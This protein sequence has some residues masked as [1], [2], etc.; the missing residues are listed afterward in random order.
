MGQ[1]T[2]QSFQVIKDKE[3]NTKKDKYG[4][5]QMQIKFTEHPETAYKA[6]KD[7]STITEGKTM[8]GSVVEG[9][10]GYRFQADPYGDAPTNSVNTGTV[11]QPAQ[12][13]Q[14]SNE[15][16]ELVKDNNRMLKALVGETTN[17]VEEPDFGDL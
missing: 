17:E 15:L 3:G 4:N 11:S 13:P 16:L 1:L 14:A 9:Q 10:Y 5:T 2:V 12:A 8:Y 7:P 6:V